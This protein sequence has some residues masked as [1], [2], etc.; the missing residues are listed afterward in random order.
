MDFASRNSRSLVERPIAADAGDEA[1]FVSKQQQ[2]VLCNVDGMIE[3]MFVEA[4]W[5]FVR[6]AGEAGS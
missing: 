1:V 4:C 2:S 3:V 6:Q 5:A